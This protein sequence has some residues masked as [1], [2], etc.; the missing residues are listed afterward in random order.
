MLLQQKRKMN[1]SV[2]LL[3]MMVLLLSTGCGANK[4]VAEVNGEKITRAQLD[5][6][7]SVLLLFMPD[8]EEMLADNTNRQ[9]LEERIVNAMIENKLLEQLS[10]NRQVT[11]TDAD[12]NIVFQEQKQEIAAMVGAEEL[13]ARM[14]ELKIEDSDIKEFIA[15][16]VYVDKLIMSM[17]SELTEEEIENYK[18]LHPTGGVV[19]ELS[20]ILL[21][22]EAEAIATRER[23]VAGED[24][25]TV[26]EEVSTDPSAAT[27][28]GYLGEVPADTVDF[29]QD[30]MAG[31][32]E[33]EV[34][35]ISQPVESEHGWHIIILHDRTLPTN[36]QVTS[37]VAAERLVNVFNEY[38]EEAEIKTLL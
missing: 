26:A 20:H 29:D 31:A 16:S 8:L 35:E 37:R 33:L 5:N 4:A 10:K 14:K 21:K 6:Y 18:S 30:F 2:A 28:K 17:A 27:N 34:D 12:I 3:L 9:A 38:Y 11:V 24:V 15:G 1:L 36:E 22:T 19:V 7:T 23:L 25:V 32:N 13:D